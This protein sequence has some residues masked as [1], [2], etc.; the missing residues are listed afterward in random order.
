[1]F[2]ERDNGELT[3][4]TDQMMLDTKGNPSLIIAGVHKDETLDNETVNR[5]ASV[6][7]LDYLSDRLLEAA[8]S[9]RLII[10]DKNRANDILAGVGVYSPERTKITSSAVDNISQVSKQSQGE[11]VN[12]TKRDAEYFSAIEKYGE[13]SKEVAK[14]V[15]QAAEEAMPDSKVRNADGKLIPA[16]HGTGRAD[17]V[18]NVFRA[19]RATS[20]P[21][22]FFTDNKEIAE[23]YAKSKRDTSIAYDTDYDSYETQ[24]R[25][26]LRGKY[27]SDIPIFKAWG[28][29]P[30]DARRR[31][32][33]K[34]KHVRIDFDGDGDIIYDPEATQANG[35]W[36]Y[37]V[38]EFK[39]DILKALNEQWLNSGNLFN[40]EERYLEVLDKAG[41]TEEFEKL[42]WDKPVYKDP[43]Y[44]EEKVYQ[45]YLNIT[46]PFDAAK[47]ADEKFIDSFL[48]WY[49]EQPYG[50]YDTESMGA[51]LWDKNLVTAEE[52]AERM[53]DDLDNKFTHAWTSIPDNMTDYLKS[54]GY[55]GIKDTGGKYTDT[56]H[57]VWIPFYSEQIKSLDPVT[58]DDE[59]NII[60]LSERFNPENEDVR[61]SEKRDSSI[62]KQ[63]SEHENELA[64]MEPVSTKEV[65]FNFTSKNDAVEWALSFF[66]GNDYKIT[67]DDIGEIIVDKKRIRN[68]LRYLKT[69]SEVKAFAYLT[70]VIKNGIIINQEEKHKGRNYD[71]VT[72]ATPIIMDENRYNMAVIIRKQDKNYYKVHKIMLPDGA[73][74]SFENKE[75]SAERAGLTENGADL[76]P[77]DAVS[78]NNI[79]S[80]DEI[81]NPENLTPSQRRD[82]EYNYLENATPEELEAVEA[83]IDRRMAE[84]DEE[85]VSLNNQ[86]A[87][88]TAQR[89]EL[90]KNEKANRDEIV[91]LNNRIGILRDRLE[92]RRE[93]VASLQGKLRRRDA[94]VDRLTEQMK[95]ARNK[96]AAFRP[97]AV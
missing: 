59:G 27:V 64:N 92:K 44:R 86:I 25:T 26:N 66:E 42:G 35:G 97:P 2:I 95:E 12:S 3:A 84:K 74:M 93:Q 32:A 36:D 24:F 77:A 40:E 91:K 30:M 52:F 22:A 81:V 71:T 88:L 54:L 68:G 85:V 72:I 37:Q 60:P 18:G 46:K 19:D 45:T 90:M 96:Q 8:N 7:P 39:G 47:Q 50:K 11:N 94:K 83:E 61:Y 56:D 28:Y 23:G 13:D 75:N 62:K 31:I 21:M 43:N 33:Q 67:R 51:D 9:G 58:R 78:T 69:A 10:T 55:D 38:Q 4:I 34:A 65:E 20:G 29:L 49:D 80:P 6:Y 5:V 48:E 89:N 17:R 57:T 1:M 70:D 82:I 16:Y 73:T 41:V 87:E 15:E 79:S 76:S 14:L 53:R 63:L